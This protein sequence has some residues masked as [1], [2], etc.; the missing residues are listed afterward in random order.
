VLWLKFAILNRRCFED[1]PDYFCLGWEILALRAPS[2]TQSLPVVERLQGFLKS[3]PAPNSA[4]VC[5]CRQRLIQFSN[6][7]VHP[8]SE[9]LVHFTEAACAI[10]GGHGKEVQS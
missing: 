7:L 8:I 4:E 1:S 9:E 3:L 5:S 6:Q 2:L 10:E